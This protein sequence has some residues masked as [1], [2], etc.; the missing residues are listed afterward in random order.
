MRIYLY[1][2]LNGIRSRCKLEKEC[3]RNIKMQWLLHGMI[4]NFN[5]IADFRKDNPIALTN[6][7]KLFKE[8]FVLYFMDLL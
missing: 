6:V 7:F 1:G 5:R 4:P 2:Y 8:R 3:A